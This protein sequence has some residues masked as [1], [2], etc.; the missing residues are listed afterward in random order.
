MT[1]DL[2]LFGQAI[3]RTF[4]ANGRARRSELIVYVVVSQLLCAV[5][6]VLAGFTLEGEPL[7][8]LRFAMFSL[9]VAPLFA[10]TARRLHDFR[11]SGK[12]TVLLW[13]VAARSI[14]LD[15]A[16]RLGGWETR[17]LIEAP[18]SYVD[19]LLFLPFVWLYVVLVIVPGNK[20]PNRFG[21]DQH[22]EPENRTAGPGSPEPA[23]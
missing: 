12:W 17:A 1:G 10:L 11:Q 4:T 14:G 13:L 6:A 19:W 18:L 20:G 7:A 23:A 2:P 9:A 22:D 5:L 15:L 3:R 16:A 8:W 21:P